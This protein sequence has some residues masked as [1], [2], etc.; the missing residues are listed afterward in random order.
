MK[1]ILFSALTLAATTLTFA[2]VTN[3]AEILPSSIQ[4][5]RNE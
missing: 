1:N 2:P 3:A 5:R 4:Q